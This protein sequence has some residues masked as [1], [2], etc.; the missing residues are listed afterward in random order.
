MARAEG[1]GIPDRWL[2]VAVS[3]VGEEQSG[4]V[5]DALVAAGGRAVVE[6][7]GAWV[8]Y[9]APPDDPEAWVGRL[10]EALAEA[11]GS[12]HSVQWGWQAHED[13]ERLWRQGLGPRRVGERL[14]VAPSWS[15]VTLEPQDVH[16]S[17]DPGMAFGTAEHATTRVA[18]A[19][20]ERAVRAGD[21]VLD[22]GTGSGIL[23][24]A[25]VRLGAAQALGIELDSYACAEAEENVL[26][27]GCEGRVQIACRAFEPDDDWGRFEGVVSNM[28][29]R[30]LQTA[31][32]GLLRAVRP[33]GWLVLSG[34]ELH[35]REGM[36]SLARRHGL[37]LV[38]SQMDEGWWGGLFRA[39]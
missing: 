5:A 26:R 12:T 14:V 6:E 2:R 31:W 4:L 18:L 34:C 8:T 16:L 1:D 33:R 38:Q 30:R 7:A 20:V 17:I 28:V 39:P 37:D 21:R 32:P 25:A 19:L 23:A 15:E 11:T 36:E 13:W 3:D 10:V 29:S 27:N 9:V 35:E 22:V 24:I